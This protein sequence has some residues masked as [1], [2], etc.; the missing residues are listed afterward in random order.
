[1]LQGGSPMDKK[2]KMRLEKNIHLWTDVLREDEHFDYAYLEI[3]ILHKVKLMRN[4]YL[5]GASPIKQSTLDLIVDEMTLV[6]EAL[7]RLI[8]DDYIN[9]PTDQT[10]TW[11]KAKN[12][13][14]AK[15]YHLRYLTDVS[16]KV[17]KKIYEAAER[18]KKRDRHLVYDT[19]RDKATGWWD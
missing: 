13:E 6:I 9:I 1:M 5:S 10:G 4:Y 11:D 12:G 8:A 3:I 7:E 17:I 15:E 18:D 2:E 14:P 19:L 16:P